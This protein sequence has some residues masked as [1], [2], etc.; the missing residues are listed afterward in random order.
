MVS[1]VYNAVYSKEDVM[2]KRF[3]FSSAMVSFNLSNVICVMNAPKNRPI[4]LSAFS[5]DQLE[6]IKSYLREYAEL[7]YVIEAEETIYVLI[8]S[9]YPSTAMSIVLRMECS[10]CEF[11]RLAREREDLFVFSPNIS[12]QASRMSARL[13]AKKKDFLDFCNGIENAFLRM[14]RHNLTFGENELREGYC[15]EITFLSSFFAV[16]I[17]KLTV[18]DAGDG[19][20][21]NCNFA[22]SVAFCSCVMML[23]RNLAHDRAISI[24]LDFSAGALKLN[25][26]FRTDVRIESVKELSIWK[27]N[28]ADR[29]ML[30][31][32]GNRDGCLY[33]NFRPYVIDLAYFGMKQKPNI[34]E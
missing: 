18:N 4:D 19:I 11:L 9:I 3:I 31:E 6:E 32:H 34:F 20:P 24:E 26:S 29:R 30:F 22:M 28:A 8:P 17:E 12:S 5:E 10:A 21:T 1:R 27:E 2:A 14:E 13:E 16:P 23:A 7:P 33:V 15:E 25:T